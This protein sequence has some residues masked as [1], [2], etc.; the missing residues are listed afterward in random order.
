MYVPS[1]ISPSD[2]HDRAVDKA[3]Q[4]LEAKHNIR[5]RPEHGMHEKQYLAFQI[6]APVILLELAFFV[7]LPRKG[8]HH[9]HACQV[10]L[11]GRGEDRLLCLIV[12]V[13]FGHL[14]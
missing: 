8:F 13:G 9:A 11:Q 14:S 1:E 10:F 7:I 3:E 12:F 4:H 2:R 5:E 6:L